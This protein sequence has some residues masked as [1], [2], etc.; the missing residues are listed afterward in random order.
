MLAASD[1][2]RH[3]G[4]PWP[5]GGSGEQS[6]SC[7]LLAVSPGQRGGGIEGQSR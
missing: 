1:P 3:R 4:E 5:F 7:A 2:R 6:S